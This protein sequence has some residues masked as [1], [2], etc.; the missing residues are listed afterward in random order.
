MPTLAVIMTDLE[1]DAFGGPSRLGELLTGRSILA[2]TVARAARIDGI[3]R[4]V[5][6]HPAGQAPLALLD[7][8]ADD[9]PKPVTTLPIE[10]GLDEPASRHWRAARKWALTCWRGGLG[11]AVCYDE[12]QPAAAIGAAMDAHQA[13]SALVVCAQW[14]AFDDKLAAAQLAQHRENPAAY[15]ICFTQAPPGLSGLVVHRELV[16]QAAAHHGGFGQALAYNPRRAALDPVGRDVNVPVAPEVRD[17]FDRLSYDTPRSVALLRAVAEHLGERF[18][19]ADASMIAAAARAVREPAEARLPQQVT[20]ELTPRRAVAGPIT[21]QHHVTFDRPDIDA[22][23]AG[24]I[25]EQL[26]EVGDVVLRLGGLGDA[27]LHPQW[28]QIVQ[29]AHDAGVLAIAIETDLLCETATLDR[30]LELPVDVVCVRFNAD[31]PQTYAKVMGRL[32]TGETDGF[33]TVANNLRHLMQ[34]RNARWEQ[35]GVRLPWIVPHLI[36][37]PETLKDMESFFDRWMIAEGHAVIQPAQTGCGL[38]PTQ[39]PMSMA[40]PR[41]APCRQLGERMSILSDGTVA[42]CD[43]D[44]LGRHPLGDARVDTLANIWGNVRDPARCH[45]EG[46]FNEVTLCASCEEWHRP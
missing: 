5:I 1:R 15:K 43:Q 31:S 20:L 45:A 41:R 28:D 40:P 3:D 17:T 22:A 2:H 36:K 23:L 38:M 25:V 34:Q 32:G 14:C 21:P 29:A 11:G 16:Q 44:W 19:E 37:T 18:I 4:I 35:G 42:L 9:Y 39:S 13:E 8:P 7:R 26:G 46:R 6:V 30:L 10:S 33:T 27:L 12:A 24:R